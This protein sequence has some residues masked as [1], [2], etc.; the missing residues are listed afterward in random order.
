MMSFEAPPGNR[1]MF[2]YFTTV[3]SGRAGGPAVPPIV[4]VMLSL[5][6]VCLDHVI[7]LP[8]HRVEIERCG[9]L[10]RRV[11]DGRLRQLG[12]L[13]LD[14][15]EPP[16]FPGEEVVAVTERAGQRSFTCERRESLEGVLA[17][18]Y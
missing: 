8:L 4:D 11:V 5:A 6:R 1:L 17:N 7:D 3:D 18:V 10:H 15:D 12:H 16:E 13:L 9:S 2:G 14:E